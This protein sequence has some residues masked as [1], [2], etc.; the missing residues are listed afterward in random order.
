[1]TRIDIEGLTMKNILPLDGALV[2]RFKFSSS[3]VHKIRIIYE[4]F[5]KSVNIFFYNWTKF[6]PKMPKLK[7]CLCIANITHQ[8]NKN[9]V[10]LRIYSII[11]N[12]RPHENF[13]VWN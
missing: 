3:Y 5:T 2:D 1:M 8:S 4:I 11:L 7:K 9:I 10:I 13:Q 12:Q 6:T